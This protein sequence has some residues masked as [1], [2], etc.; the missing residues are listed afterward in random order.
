MGWK[1]I[2]TNLDWNWTA[3]EK[4]C[5]SHCGHVLNVPGTYGA[6]GWS[7]SYATIAKNKCPNLHKDRNVPKGVML[8]L[9]FDWYGYVKGLGT[10]WWGHVAVY[11][12]GVIRTAPRKGHLFDPKNNPKYGYETF[13][14]ISDLEKAFGCTYV[15]WSEYFSNK[16]IAKYEPDVV[17]PKSVERNDKVPQIEVYADNL[18]TRKSPNGE[19]WFSYCNVGIFDVLQTVQAGAY[20]WIEIDSGFWIALNEKDKWNKLLEVKEDE[21]TELKKKVTELEKEV[22]TKDAIID[23]VRKVV[24]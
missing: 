18:R 8:M 19:S 1:Q 6:S 13:N 14:S 17:S 10:G 5:L 9:Y 7:E 16:Q 24:E 12:D 20:T 21:V 23:E 11:K 4:N 15:G 22:A 3:S 2:T